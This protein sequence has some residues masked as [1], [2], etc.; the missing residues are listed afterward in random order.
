MHFTGLP[1]TISSYCDTWY[2]VYLALS[3]YQV[4]DSNEVYIDYFKTAVSEKPPSDIFDD[5]N[6]NLDGLTEACFL[7]ILE[8]NF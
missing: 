4:R 8:N 1:K 3:L 6:E 5:E 2:E 7:N